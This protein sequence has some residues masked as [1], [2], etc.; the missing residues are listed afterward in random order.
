MYTLVEII[1]DADGLVGLSSEYGRQLWSRCKVRKQHSC[2]ECEQSFPVG[3]EMY[4]PITNGYNRMRRLCENCVQ[5]G[6]IA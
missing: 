2:Q 6:G 1:S 5:H 3:S 4:R